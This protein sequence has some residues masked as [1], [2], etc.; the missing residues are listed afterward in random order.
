MKLMGPGFRRFVSIFDDPDIPPVRDRPFFRS[1]I[2]ELTG[3]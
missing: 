3:G 1:R 2:P